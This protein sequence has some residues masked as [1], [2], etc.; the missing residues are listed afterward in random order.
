[1]EQKLNKKIQNPVQPPKYSVPPVCIK[2][3]NPNV[4][5]SRALTGRFYERFSVQ[6]V[7]RKLVLT[8]FQLSFR[9]PLN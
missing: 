6:P 3:D 1:M 8:A 4:G 7:L 5:G 2:T 9:S